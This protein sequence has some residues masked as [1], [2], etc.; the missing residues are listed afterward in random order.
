M[1]NDHINIAALSIEDLNELKEISIDTF[2]E[3]FIGGNSEKN[4][5]Q[6]IHL[7]FTEEILL[8]EINNP[9]SEF[10]FAKIKETVV[11]YLKVNIGKA[12]TELQ[13]QEGIE[14]ER[15]YVRQ[16]F[17]G[18]RI[19]QLLYDKALEIAREKAAVYVW[20]GVWEKN[21]GAIKF[22][23]RNGLVKFATHPFQLGD[24]LQTD[25]MMKLEL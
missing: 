13:D 2:Y 4:M 15:I 17:Q 3:S 20:L 19:G 14:I 21:T 10:Y 1:N 8:E 11:G 22:Y 7:Y 6:Y 12:Q 18:N 23:E 5:Q 24:D 9:D 25:I 16:A